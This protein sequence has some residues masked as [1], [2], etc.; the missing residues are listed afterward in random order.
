MKNL[1]TTFILTFL[2][3]FLFSCSDDRSFYEN[4]INKNIV[5]SNDTTLNRSV[6]GENDVKNIANLHNQ[7][8]EQLIDGFNFK[9]VNYVNEV[10]NQFNQ[11]DFPQNVYSERKNDLYD[12]S[13]YPEIYNSYID[14]DSKLYD[15]II[16]GQTLISKNEDNMKGIEQSMNDLIEKLNMMIRLKVNMR[17]KQH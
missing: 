15:Y 11:L 7:Y 3:L 1:K 12:F 9:N 10:K 13:F 17:R 2:A 8:L 4:E 5:S 14:E 16:I 6:L